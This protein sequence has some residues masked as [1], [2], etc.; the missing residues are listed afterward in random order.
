MC[1]DLHHTDW[2]FLGLLELDD[3]G[4][5]AG[6]SEAA[7]RGT[8][9]IS[10]FVALVRVYLCAVDLIQDKCLGNLRYSPAPATTSLEDSSA[11]STLSSIYS[12]SQHDNSQKSPVTFETGMRVLRNLDR[13]LHLIPRDFKSTDE[14]GQF[15][16]V[17]H[18]F[19]ISRAN[20][21]ITQVYIQSIVLATLS[22]G[23][24]MAVQGNGSPCHTDPGASG[25]LQERIF[26]DQELFKLGLRVA[27][28]SSD[29]LS[30]NPG[31]ALE[32]NGRAMVS[33]NHPQLQ[34]ITI[35]ATL[36]VLVPP[37]SHCMTGFQAPRNCFCFNELRQRS[38]KR[39]RYGRES[40]S[41]S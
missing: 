6:T 10:G 13:T 27:Q 11:S 2:E 29:A 30:A 19:A 9:L 21:S 31:E 17:S 7:P 33:P 36:P 38:P 32:A 37:I 3:F 12:D 40:R 20:I 5:N 18:P 26:L 1:H 25:Q 41:M 22:A 39:R 23:T 24:S 28:D 35:I 15:V 16:D 8:Q 4:T 34:C 14:D